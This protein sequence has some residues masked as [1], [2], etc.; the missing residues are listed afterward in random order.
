MELVTA[1]SKWVLKE[2]GVLRVKKV[3][4]HLAG[5]KEVPREYTIM[6]EVVKPLAESS[7]ALAFGLS[8][9]GHIS[10]MSL[11]LGFK[12]SGSCVWSLQVPS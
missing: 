7:L 11:R 2:N 1:L 8:K 5:S 12:L 3:E 10:R 6:D 4:H 9:Q